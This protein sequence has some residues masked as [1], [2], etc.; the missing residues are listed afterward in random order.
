MPI[1]TLALK[2]TNN[3]KGSTLELPILVSSRSS[4]NDLK[5]IRHLLCQFVVICLAQLDFKEEPIDLLV[6]SPV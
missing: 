4:A 5:M 2:F 6:I 3:T 1:I